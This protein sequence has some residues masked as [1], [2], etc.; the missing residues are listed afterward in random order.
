MFDAEIPK[1]K[2]LAK[3][4]AKIESNAELAEINVKIEDSEES[5]NLQPFELTTEASTNFTIMNS[6][7]QAEPLDKKDE[8]KYQKFVEC[9]EEY[10]A[11][12]EI[13][14]AQLE[15]KFKEL[16]RMI[17]PKLVTHFKSKPFEAVTAAVLLYSCREVNFP[18][19]L[20]QIVSVSDAKE[21]LI[22]KCVFSM[23]EIICSNGEK[24]KLFKAGEFIQVLTEKL[25]IN[26]NVKNSAIKVWENIESLNF[27]KSIHAVTLASC[28]LKFAC[29]L[30]DCD[31]DFE[32]IALAAGITKMTLKNMYRE[33]YPY[34]LHFITPN[35]NLHDPR[36]LK[37]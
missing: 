26:E 29:A 25:S 14:N 22:N 15:E 9:L 35:C 10:V 11:K 6:P 23:K 20:K 2:N 16:S 37:S 31:R 18:I 34:R 30:S 7:P 3:M 1:N 5:Q 27:V 19:T 33:L 13:K 36:D 32:T 8:K 28:C 17:I 21:K 4:Q 24:V 12:L